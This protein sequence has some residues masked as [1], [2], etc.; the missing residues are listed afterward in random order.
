MFELPIEHS[1]HLRRTNPIES[2]FAT[3]RLRTDAARRFRTARSGVHLV[4]KLLQ[5]AEQNCLRIT[6]AEKLKDVKLPT[7]D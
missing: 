4:F 2:V 6:F 7:E 3:V 5:R 1:K